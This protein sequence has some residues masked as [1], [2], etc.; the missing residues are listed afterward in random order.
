ML[1]H[2]CYWGNNGLQKFILVDLHL[3]YRI[4]LN[5]ILSIVFGMKTVNIKRSK[6]KRKTTDLTVF[7]SLV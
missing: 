3:S 7:I 4:V 6:S 5:H 1:G 2:T